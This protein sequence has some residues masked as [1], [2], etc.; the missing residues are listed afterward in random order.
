MWGPTFTPD[1]A[2]ILYRN[3]EKHARRLYSYRVADGSVEALPGVFEG[4]LRFSLS[5]DGHSVA[6]I[7]GKRNEIGDD[8]TEIRLHSAAGGADEVLWTTDDDHRFGRWTAWTPNGKALLV[9]RRE[10]EDEDMWR[11]WV[12]PVDGSEPVG[13]ELVYEPANGGAQRLDIHPDGQRVVY[14]SGSYGVQFWAVRNLGL[15]PG[16]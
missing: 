2:R 15:D 1:G 11:L 4:N 14:T 10:D 12:V 3:R 5:P 13:T 16:R 7:S 8:A 9:L 6:T